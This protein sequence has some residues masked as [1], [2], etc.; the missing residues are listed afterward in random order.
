M[1]YVR[2]RARRVRAGWGVTAAGRYVRGASAH[3]GKQCCEATQASCI[4]KEF[5]VKLQLVQLQTAA[6]GAVLQ[7]QFSCKLLP[8]V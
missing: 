1:S 6:S 2:I 4:E 3:A 7:I 5:A 8:A